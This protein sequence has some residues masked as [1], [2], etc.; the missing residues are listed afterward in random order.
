M[1]LLTEEIKRQL[2]SLYSTEDV[3][4]EDKIAIC[5]FFTPGS[6]WTWYAVEYDG[7]D[8][9]FGYVIGFVG[10]WG[11]FSLSELESVR[12]ALGLPIE[13]D[14]YFDPQPIKPYLVE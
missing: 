10:E 13:R 5:K 2:P 6:N 11:Y 1:K 7:E 12:G 4:V 14:L 8:L 3:D 9:F